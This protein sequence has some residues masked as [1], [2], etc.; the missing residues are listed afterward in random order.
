ML[1]AVQVSSMKTS[2]VGVEIGLSVEPGAPLAQDVR[3]VLLDRVAGLLFRVITRRWK[4]RDSADLEVAI[5][6]AV[7][8]SQSSTSVWSRSSS[9]AAITSA[10]HASIRCERVSPP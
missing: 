7:S 5:P 1:V 10:P 9:K 4:N 2:R 6:R 3:M 8:R